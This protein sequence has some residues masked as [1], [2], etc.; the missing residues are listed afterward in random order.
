MGGTIWRYRR[1]INVPKRGIGAATIAKIN[2]FAAERGMSFYDT[3]LRIQAVPG[4]G[5]AASKIQGFTEEIGRLRLLLEEGAPVE[6]VIQETIDSHRLPGGINGRR[7]NRGPD[8]LGE[9]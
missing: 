1:I 3:L 8:P 2:L 5:R 6:D 7:G 4:I 9:Y